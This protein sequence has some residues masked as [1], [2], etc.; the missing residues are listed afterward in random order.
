MPTGAGRVGGDADEYQAVIHPE[1]RHVVH[2]FHEQA[3]QE[4]CFSGEYRIVRPDGSI[5][6][7][8]GHGQ[9][10]ARTP[11]GKAQHLVSIVADVSDRKQAENRMRVSELRYRRLF[12]AADDGVLVIDPDTLKIIDANPFM[13]KLLGYSHDAFVGMELF[14]IGLL[15]DAT[16]SRYM[17]ERLEKAHQVRYEDL[18]LESQTGQHQQAGSGGDPLTTK[19]RPRLALLNAT[20]AKFLRGNRSRP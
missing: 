20:S 5:R 19:R 4:D 11:D 7:L 2:R 10:V 16:A 13:T 14:E 18:P 8:A 3:D 9:V 17:V 15:K 12:E 6:W 1:D